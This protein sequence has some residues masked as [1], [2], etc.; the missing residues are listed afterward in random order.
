MTLNLSSVENLLDS[1]LIK[2]I[3]ID[4]KI[5]PK[6]QQNISEISI[7]FINLQHF[8]WRFNLL[9][10]IKENTFIDL[11]KLQQLNLYWNQL[12][13]IKENTFNVL[14]N[15]QKLNLERK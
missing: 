7:D 3:E 15:L 13:D 6:D 11:N 1:N 2:K 9:T 8:S 12:R 4:K 14:N 5:N 10:E